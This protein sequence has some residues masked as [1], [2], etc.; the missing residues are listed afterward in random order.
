MKQSGHL[1]HIEET[2]T[3]C[4]VT[5]KYGRTLPNKHGSVGRQEVVFLFCSETILMPGDVSILKSFE[6]IEL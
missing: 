4:P 5:S 1:N 2:G 6:S 3:G